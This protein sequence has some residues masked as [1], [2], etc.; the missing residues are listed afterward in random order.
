MSS[1]AQKVN[2]LEGYMNRVQNKASVSQSSTKAKCF[3]TM[4]VLGAVVPVILFAIL[5]FVSPS[6]VQIQD[7]NGQ[8]TR[9]NTKVFYWT[10]F[11]STLVW[12][13]MF[14]F[15]YC[16]GYKKSALLCVSN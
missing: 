12:V 15:T 6:F 14:L 2:E 9:S 8:Y 4:V 13:G 3:P 16:R 7:D 5:F 11:A 1:Y 10:L